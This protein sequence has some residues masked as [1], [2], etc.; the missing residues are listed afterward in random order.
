M[1]KMKLRLVSTG[2][3]RDIA[4]QFEA[5]VGKDIERAML[6]VVTKSTF[7]M[8]NRLVR[9]VSTGGRS[10]G[11]YREGTATEHQASAPGEPPKSDTGNL[12]KNININTEQKGGMI[13]GVVSINTPYAAALEF[14][15]K[16]GTL[17]ARPY[18][19]PARDAERPLFEQAATLALRKVMADR[20]KGKKFGKGDK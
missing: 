6:A 20:F 16:K 5:A 13:L 17:L 7:S 1:A 8:H 12:V 14:G 3:L 2:A 10:G 15:N 19:K 18:M 9:M 4:K 11:I